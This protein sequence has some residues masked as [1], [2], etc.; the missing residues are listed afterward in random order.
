MTTILL[1]CQLCI[2]KYPVISLRI[3]RRYIINSY[4][5]E[6]EIGKQLNECCVCVYKDG[7]RAC[8]TRYLARRDMDCGID[9]IPV[10]NMH[11]ICKKATTMA[12]VRNVRKVIG[13]YK[14]ILRAFGTMT[15]LFY[16]V[17]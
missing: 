2:I 8:A 6:H 9:L 10:M 3:E 4:N 17:I 5:N 16:I 1:W 11:D 7:R 13:I 15:A 12:E 14:A